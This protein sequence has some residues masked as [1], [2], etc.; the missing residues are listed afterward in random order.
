[1]SKLALAT[2]FPDA[3]PDSNEIFSLHMNGRIARVFTYSFPQLRQAADLLGPL[4]EIVPTINNQWQEVGW[5][6]GNWVTMAYVFVDAFRDLIASGRIKKVQL[7][8]EPDIWFLQPPVGAPDTRLTPEWCASMVAQVAGI[9]RD[10]GVQVI[11]PSVASGQWP[12][13]L[14][15]MCAELRRQVPPSIRLWAD[16]HLY[17]K[18][19]DNHPAYP[20]WQEMRDALAT[21]RDIAQLPVCSTEGGIKVQDAGGLNGHAEWTRRWVDQTEA[22]NEADFPFCT[23][24]A[25]SDRSGAP[26]EQWDQGFCLRDPNGNRRPAWTTFRDAIN[27]TA[28]P[29]PVPSVPEVPH[30]VLGFEQMFLSNPG[31]VGAPT[32]LDPHEFGPALGVSLQRSSNGLLMFANTVESGGFLG[33]LDLRDNARYRWDGRRLGR[34]AG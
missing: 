4:V 15:R 28:D 7:I 16:L 11:I 20:D 25:W 30:Y 21:A 3:C 32:Q 34:I 2:S 33:Y 8:N 22:L 9:F 29:I 27:G 24:F 12:D 31:L 6:W 5:D 1:M 13:Y 26:G 14:R 17:V 18:K 19:I 23:Y 10:A